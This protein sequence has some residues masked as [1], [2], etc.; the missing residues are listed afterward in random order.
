MSGKKAETG[1][2]KVVKLILV[3][4]LVGVVLLTSASCVFLPRVLRGSGNVITE[5]RDVKDFNK[6]ALTGVGNLIIEQGDGESLTIEA[7]DNILPKIV[8]RVKNGELSIG[9]VGGPTPLPTED[10]KFYLKVKDLSRIAL[11][12]TGVITSSKFETDNLEF[13][14]SGAGEVNFKVSVDTI[15]TIVS[16]FGTIILAGDTGKQEVRVSGAGSYLAKD[17]VSK[18]CDITISGAG[19]A[20]VNV[21]EKLNVVISGAGSVNYIGNPEINQKITGPG[22]IKNIE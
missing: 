17:L 21:S 18:E 6:A 9:F 8:T 15:K 20:T 14:L 1:G 19:S 22:S 10:I 7:E 2:N 12:G 3:I 4:G 16:G 5:E 11:S 13:D